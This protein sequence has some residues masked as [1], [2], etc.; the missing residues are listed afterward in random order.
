ME[1]TL[2]SAV[3]GILVG[4]LYGLAALGL[5]LVFGVLKVLN[6]AHG[7]LVMLGGYVT[8]FA[9]TSWGLDPFVALPV[10]F[11]VLGAVGA[12]LHL[13][14]F[15]FVVR[16]DVEHRIKNSLLIAFGLTLVIQALAIRAFTADERGV[17]ATY[18]QAAWEV[19]PLRLPVI[20]VAG[21]A[22][23]IVAVA[24]LGWLL[25]NTSLGRAVRATSENWALASLA[26]IDVGRVYLITFAIAAALA[27]ITG[28]LVVLGFSVSPSIGLSWTLKALIVVVLAGLGSIRGTVLA[29]V[30]LGLV[31]GLGS[32]W[33]GGQY[34]EITALVV[35]LTV[36]LVRPQ[37]LFGGAHA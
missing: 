32:V 2:Q 8:F 27:G 33:I 19:G 14:L 5:A 28:T 10:A 34:R 37:G 30:L 12:G 9:V 22:I 36:L 6:V 3:S 17:V 11:V 16:F 26:G 31:E 18:S 13:G 15:R 25:S 35:F 4:G 21:L 24:V 1:L 20:R 29:G 7:E 23:A